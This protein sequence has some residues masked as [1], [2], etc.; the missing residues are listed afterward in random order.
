MAQA[1]IDYYN[2]YQRRIQFLRLDGD[3]LLQ[4]IKI[5]EVEMNRKKQQNQQPIERN[6][7][8]L[9]A[10]VKQLL[11]ML[12]EIKTCQYF[13]LINKPFTYY[14]YFTRLC[15]SNFQDLLRQFITKL[16]IK[17]IQRLQNLQHLQHL[18]YLQTQLNYNNLVDFQQQAVQQPVN[19]QVRQ[20]Q[21]QQ[22][23]QQLVNLIQQ[24]VQ[25]PVDFQV[26]R[27]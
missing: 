9:N 2:Y 10:M 26:Q 24:A 5:L 17:R 19:F 4:Q 16:R 14:H 21:Q 25:Q 23:Q 15:N 3:L 8:L 12:A 13:Q 11:Q 7:N 6:V 22:Q 18:Q 20:Q 1:I 27:L